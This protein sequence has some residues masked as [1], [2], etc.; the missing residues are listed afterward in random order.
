MKL[1]DK[2]A[3]VTGGKRTEQNAEHNYRCSPDDFHKLFLDQPTTV[4]STP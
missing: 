1:K 4:S 2:V 3:I